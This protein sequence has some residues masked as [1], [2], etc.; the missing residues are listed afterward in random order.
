MSAPHSLPTPQAYAHDLR[1]YVTGLVLAVVL[2]VVPFAM[3][4]SHAFGFGTT[5]AVIA[6]FGLIQAG[7]HLRYFLHVDLSRDKRNERIL[8]LFSLLLLLL[9]VAGTIWIMINLNV[10]MMEMPMGGASL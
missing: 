10:R 7:V 9:M 5:V 1:D 2:T 6:A 4:A 3:V 8:I